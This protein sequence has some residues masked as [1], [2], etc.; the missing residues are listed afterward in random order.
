V[1]LDAAEAK[2][3]GLVDGGMYSI[4]VFQAE[5]HTC[6]STY[7]LT[8]GGFL[9]TVSQCQ[10]VCGDGIVAGTEQCDNGTNNGA[11]GTCNSNCTLAPYC[12]DDKVQTPPEQCDDGSNEATY[13]GTTEECGPGCKWAPY[14]GDGVR[15]GPETCDQG[16]N[17]QAPSSAYGAGVCT[18]T[19][20]AAP[21]CGDA[22]TQAQFGEQCDNGKND[23]SYGTCNPNCTLAPYCGDG[24]VQNPPEQ[25]DNGTS[26]QSPSTAYGQG[27]CTTACTEAP[28]CGDG[29]VQSQFGE[30]C[31][32]TPNCSAN[33]QNN[34]PPK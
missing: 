18:T 22:I 19:C 26:N 34:G 17:N 6:G 24:K 4:D 8:L 33:C 32:S 15:N 30:Q 13:G 21:Y 27:I 31:D 3:L 12:G 28:Y 7:Q 2:T 29:I 9:H 16:S 25:C 5:R 23:G 14:C 1:T 20:L 11:Y 10:T